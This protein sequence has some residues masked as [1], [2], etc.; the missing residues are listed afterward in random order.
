MRHAILASILLAT[1]AD[2]FT[3]DCSSFISQA[4][5]IPEPWEAHTR[6]FAN[7]DV[8]ISV[9]DTVEPA[10]AA[11]HLLILSPPLN[12]LGERQ[13]RVVSLNEGPGGAGFGFA[14]LTLDGVTSA[15]SPA[16]GLVLTLEIREYAPESGM[17]EPARLAVTINQATGD[18]TSEILPD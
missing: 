5:N 9:L 7:G 1:P 10:A 6:V 17:F 2:A 15:Y 18:V 14:G 8:R 3:H 16:N 4:E 12:D 11:L 13:C